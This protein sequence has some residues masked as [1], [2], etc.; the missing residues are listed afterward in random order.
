[1]NKGVVIYFNAYCGKMH[2]M[3]NITMCQTNA[4]ENKLSISQPE[5]KMNIVETILVLDSKE[6]LCNSD[7]DSVP[8]PIMYFSHAL[9]KDTKIKCNVDSFVL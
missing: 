4:I 7:P 5:R 1:M 9:I 2:C 3:K 8:P 6:K